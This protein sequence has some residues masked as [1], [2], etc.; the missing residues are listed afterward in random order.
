MRKKKKLKAPKEPKIPKEPKAWG[1]LYSFRIPKK[2]DEVLNPEPHTRSLLVEGLLKDTKGTC[3]LC[4][5]AWPTKNDT[6]ERI[7]IRLNEATH[8]AVHKFPS[9]YVRAWIMVGLGYCPVCGQPQEN[10]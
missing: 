6:M 1:K 5:N 4:E 10:K 8:K 3:P 9:A 2:M 7:G